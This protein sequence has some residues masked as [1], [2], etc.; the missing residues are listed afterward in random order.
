MVID[1]G[2][3]PVILPPLVVISST[4]AQI[5]KF[6]NCRDTLFPPLLELETCQM[7]EMAL[8]E[9]VEIYPK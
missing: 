2:R 3:K 5:T 9:F 6:T 7:R 4:K 8:G 1:T